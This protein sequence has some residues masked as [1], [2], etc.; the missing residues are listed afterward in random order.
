MSEILSNEMK[1]IEVL[2][3]SLST[4]V[5]NNL[6]NAIESLKKTDVEMAKKVISDD[7]EIDRMEIELEEECLKI[8]ALHQPVAIDLRFII[9]VLKI[10]NDLERIGD[11]S[12]NI[13]QIVL[14][15]KNV[16]SFN[17]PNTILDMTEVVF[18]MLKNSLDSILY[19]DSN[20]AKKVLKSDNDVDK[21]HQEMYS[22]V[23][24]KIMGGSESDFD[25]WLPML[26]VSRYLERIA[27][28]C[29]NIAE[30]VDYLITGHISRH[31]Q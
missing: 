10:N 1:K 15:Y 20:L 22:L 4:I 23:K 29:T 25:R 18:D 30:D 13:C 3:S 21:L 16:E 27:D 14:I 11:L 5:D 9:A 2:L 24:N 12:S 19:R 17:V 8:L 31:G 7:S 26:S 6:R 28:H